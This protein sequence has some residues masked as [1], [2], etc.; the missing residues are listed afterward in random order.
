MVKPL[1]RRG[2]DGIWEVEVAGRVWRHSQPWQVAVFYEMALAMV[3]N[4]QTRVVS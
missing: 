2:D 1:V 4:Q 3:T